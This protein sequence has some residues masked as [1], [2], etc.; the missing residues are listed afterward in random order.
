MRILARLRDH[1]QLGQ[2]SHSI[3]LKNRVIF[4]GE[5]AIRLELSWHRAKKEGDCVT[6]HFTNHPLFYFTNAFLGYNSHGIELK[7]EGD[8]V[9]MH[10]PITLF[11]FY[12]IISPLVNACLCMY[13]GPALSLSLSRYCALLYYALLD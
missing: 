1:K 11:L 7:K 4:G 5:I 3:E 12:Q 13:D 6:M 8:C 2:N 10:L 9:S